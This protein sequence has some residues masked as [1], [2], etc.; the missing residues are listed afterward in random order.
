MDAIVLDANAAHR[1]TVTK[2]R[3]KPRLPKSVLHAWRK[4]WL[5]RFHDG[6]GLGVMAFDDHR[7]IKVM[8]G[9]TE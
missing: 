5:Y 9:A 6:G 1:A 4:L 3:P 2:Y 7:G 8:V